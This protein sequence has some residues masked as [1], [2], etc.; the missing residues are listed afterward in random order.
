MRA[1]RPAFPSASLGAW[2]RHIV[3]DRRC[4]LRNPFC[5]VVVARGAS[6]RSRL[7][8][9]EPALL[10][11]LLVTRPVVGFAASAGVFAAD[12]VPPCAAVDR[13]PRSRPPATADESWVCGFRRRPPSGPG[14]FDV[15]DRARGLRIGPRDPGPRE[16]NETDAECHGQ[17][18]DA[19][20]IPRCAHR[21]L[22]AWPPE[23][24]LTLRES[25]RVLRVNCRDRQNALRLR[26]R[27]MHVVRIRHTFASLSSAAD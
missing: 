14:A 16:H 19:P 8:G 4:S 22:R 24:R 7:V 5:A 26:A 6:R 2:L 3:G 10:T 17:P 20:D 21:I 23:T 25:A 12:A 9:G 18:A 11:V 27:H 1:S 15:D 13:A